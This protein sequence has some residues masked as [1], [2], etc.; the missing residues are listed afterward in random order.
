VMV[1]IIAEI[2]VTQKDPETFEVTV[3]ESTTTT[4]TVKLRPDYYKR[5]TGGKAT[6]EALIKESFLF[7]LERESNTM[8]LPSFKLPM[9]SQY[10]PEYEKTVVRQLKR[11]IT[12]KVK[13]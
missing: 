6:P 12:K 9:I 11:E 3:T 5:L 4:H 8:V 13:E 7:L 2:Q 1:V 10:F